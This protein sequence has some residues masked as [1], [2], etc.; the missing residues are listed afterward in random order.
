M[1]SS[2]IAANSAF[3]QRCSST[4][5]ASTARLGEARGELRRDHLRRAWR[6]QGAT[7]YWVAVDGAATA[8]LVGATAVELPGP[9]VL[10]CRPSLSAAGS[11]APLRLRLRLRLRGCQLC[12][13]IVVVILYS[14]S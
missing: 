12:P 11:V 5:R 4:K 1:L 2:P 9:T 10:H 6:A 7:S 13:I 3:S 14:T 8:R